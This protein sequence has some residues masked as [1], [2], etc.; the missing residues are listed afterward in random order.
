[1]AISFIIHKIPGENDLSY[2]T[3]ALFV[4]IATDFI[5]KKIWSRKWQT[6]VHGSVRILAFHS[7]ETE[8]GEAFL[9]QEKEGSP[10]EVTLFLNK[11]LLTILHDL[12]HEL[13]HVEQMLSRQLTASDDSGQLSLFSNE[14][15]KAIRSWQTK[16][17]F[18]LVDGVFQWDEHGVPKFG[19]DDIFHSV[20][21]E[22]YERLKALN[23]SPKWIRDC[24]TFK[25][26][27]MIRTEL[28]AVMQHLRI[29]SRATAFRTEYLKAS[30]S[31]VPDSWSDDHQEMKWRGKNVK[32]AYVICP[33]EEDARAKER[34]WTKEFLSDT[35]TLNP[36]DSLSSIEGGIAHLVNIPPYLRSV[37]DCLLLETEP[38]ALKLR[39]E[40]KK[41]PRRA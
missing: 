39:I 16:G 32:I 34:E 9:F 36:D 20:N 33:W 11:P 18:D 26:F 35:E 7:P 30:Q 25:Q 12:C 1:M 19:P 17:Y 15:I 21:R 31:H 27:R 29:E 28:Y 23:T 5:F 3:K 40:Q 14:E 6:S 41:K 10:L 37:V 38:K 4:E 8:E 24:K 13:R 2:V 22:D